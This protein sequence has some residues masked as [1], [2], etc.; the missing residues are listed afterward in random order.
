MDFCFPKCMTP[1]DISKNEMIAT[2]S[3]VE[4]Y[5]D[6]EYKA[7][8]F[9]LGSKQTYIMYYRYAEEAGFLNVYIV[10]VCDHRNKSTNIEMI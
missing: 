7:N 2:C 4:S 5:A 1:N 8:F 6:C 9:H 10:R 3:Y